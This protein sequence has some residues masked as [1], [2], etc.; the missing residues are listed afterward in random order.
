[1]VLKSHRSLFLLQKREIRKVKNLDLVCLCLVK[2]LINRE[3]EL[4]ILQELINYLFVNYPVAYSVY[5]F[6]LL[7]FLLTFDHQELVLK[8]LEYFGY[9]YYPEYK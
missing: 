7:S 9:P 1:M 2:G 5:N 3:R 8:Y 6:E 4:E